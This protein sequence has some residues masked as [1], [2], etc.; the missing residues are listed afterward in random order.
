MAHRKTK[1]SSTGVRGEPLRQRVIEAAERLLRD[2]R[3]D[4]SM[5]DLAA[6]AGVSFATPF[7]QFGSKA[8]IMHTLSAHRIDT[9]E[10]RFVAAP[11]L[12]DATE[13]V[14]LAIDTAAAVMLEEPKVNRAVMGWLGTA[15]SAPGQVW[16]RSTA[17]WTLALGAGDGLIAAR[18]EQALRSLPGQ[19]AFAFRGVLSF[20]TAGELPD[21]A[22]AP[23][24]RALASTLLLGFTDGKA[25]R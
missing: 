3:A 12:T 10:S 22:L 18:R 23:N 15:S 24:A 8:A 19:L 20:W 5:R 17:L 13:R 9:M 4:F 7:N 2:G 21:E 6:E 16:E 11:P 1:P 14:L 25:I